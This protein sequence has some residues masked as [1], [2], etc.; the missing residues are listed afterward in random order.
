MKRHAVAS[1]PLDTWVKRQRTSDAR[2]AAGTP[3]APPTAAPAEPSAAADTGSTSGGPLSG[4]VFACVGYDESELEDM[5]NELCSNGARVYG[6]VDPDVCTHVLTEQPSSAAARAAREGGEV[7]VVDWRWVM[8]RVSDAPGEG[9]GVAE[10]QPPASSADVAAAD[11]DTPLTVVYRS[12]QAMQPSCAVPAPAAAAAAAAAPPRQREPWQLPASYVDRW[13]RTHVRLPCSPRL[14]SR[15]GSGGTAWSVLTST[16]SSPPRHVRTLVGAMRTIRGALGGVWT[17]RGTHHVVATLMSDAERAIF[18]DRTLPHMCALALRLPA[19][20]PSGVPLLLRGRA[21]DVD[22]TAEQCGCLMAH[23]FFCTFPGRLVAPEDAA[24][25][26]RTAAPPAGAPLLPYFSWVYLHGEGALSDPTMLQKWRCLLG[27]FDARAL[28]AASADADAHAS[29][30]VTFTRL[31]GDTSELSLT[32]SND[33][34]WSECDAPLCDVRASASGVIEDA[35]AGTLQL[36]FANRRVGGGVLRHGCVMEE[37]R[38][39]CCPELV[40]ARLLAEE[41]ADNE[42]LLIRGFDTYSK[43]T[44]YA[45]SFRHAGPARPEP[46]AAASAGPPAELLCIDATFYGR[47]P[48][49]RAAQWGVAAVERELNKAYVGFSPRAGAPMLGGVCTGNWGCGAFGGDPEL[50]AVVQWL[51]AS[52]A[53]RP[54]L[55]YLTFGDAAL[56]SAL[57]GLRAELADAGVRTVGDLAARL[58]EHVRH[59]ADATSTYATWPPPTGWADVHTPPPLL[60]VLRGAPSAPCETRAPP[61]PAGAADGNAES[62][63]WAEAAAV[64]DGPDEHR[65]MREAAYAVAEED[66]AAWEAALEGEAAAEAEAEAEA[67]WAEA[68]EA[69]DAAA[70]TSGWRRKRSRGE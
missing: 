20:F 1:G 66:E 2:A 13:D 8:K 15:L 6:V 31:V 42:A 70:A 23:A 58:A 59:V 10:E 53:R 35:P 51:A 47:S 50:K 32:G 22:L 38:F 5:R 57:G 41:L 55:V 67:A 25:P 27:Y 37:I 46:A 39:L 43:H 48:E 21:R 30:T 63:R 29:R 69:S 36:D 52:R 19:L 56:A 12:G 18:F 45:G 24:Q 54:E 62:A 16:L 28:R 7:D 14:H 49:E 44:G 60:A 40:V 34:A 33:G 17:L 61:P 11:V 3:P 4:L 9:P 65:E 64:R 68:E 26:T